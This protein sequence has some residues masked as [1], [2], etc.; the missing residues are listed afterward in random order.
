M[1]RC[2]ELP[3]DEREKLMRCDSR[4]RQVHAGDQPDVTEV[5]PMS[6]YRFEQGFASRTQR[7]YPKNQQRGVVATAVLTRMPSP[8]SW[9]RS[10]L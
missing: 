2:P 9:R 7:E 4:E 8:V 5:P 3:S 10:P 1:N 6:R